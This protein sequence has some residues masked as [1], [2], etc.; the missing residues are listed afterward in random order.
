MPK[1]TSFVVVAFLFC[2]LLV[3]LAVPGVNSAE[4]TAAKPSVLTILKTPLLLVSS[5]LPSFNVVGVAAE[6]KTIKSGKPAVPRSKPTGDVGIGK[7]SGID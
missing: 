5:I 4:K 7:P 2:A 1:K 6:S 3:T